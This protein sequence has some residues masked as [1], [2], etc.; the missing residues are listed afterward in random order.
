MAQDAQPNKAL[1]G[2]ELAKIITNDITN[3]LE[4]DGMLTGH[5][6]YT[7]VAY[8]IT[9]KIMTAN[10]IIPNWTNKTKSKTS[11]EQQVAGNEALAAVHAFPLKTADGDETA[12]I[13]VERTRQI[14]SPNQSRIEN[15]LPISVNLR[16]PD[17]DIREEKVHYDVEM[18]PDDGGYPDGVEE[19]ELSDAEIAKED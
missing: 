9:V 8:S 4:Q 10:P 6:A 12:N 18:L 14:I 5:I 15:G 16:G 7:K 2:V 17:G 1:S 19:R 3:I 13:G 11:T